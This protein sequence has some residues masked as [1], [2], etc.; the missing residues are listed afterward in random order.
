MRLS[1]LNIFFADF[2]H[3][4]Y[5]LIVASI[6]EICPCVMSREL[7]VAYSSRVKF[8]MLA[9]NLPAHR[10]QKRYEMEPP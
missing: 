1:P 3:R 9:Y 2:I 5:S 7:T 8:I 4:F 6:N 10:K